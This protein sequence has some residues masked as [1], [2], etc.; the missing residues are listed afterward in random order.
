MN[1]TTEALKMAIEAG[2]NI[3]GELARTHPFKDAEIG[4]WFLS[5]RNAVNACI[6]VLEDI[7]INNWGNAASNSCHH[8]PLTEALKMA[9]E[10]LKIY[11]DQMCGNDDPKVHAELIETLEK[12]VATKFPTQVYT[13]E[14]ILN[15]V[16]YYKKESLESQE[17]TMTY[18]QG[19]EH[20][21]E[22]YRAEEKDKIQKEIDVLGNVAIS[23]EQDKCDGCGCK[24]CECGER[25]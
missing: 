8:T 23:Q 18:E 9:I 25:K 22:A 19:F 4:M 13:T 24:Y 17:H 3:L 21:Y 20:G 6:E 2:E 10:R 11:H 7:E 12:L 1:K 16:G 15:S 14:E 5:V